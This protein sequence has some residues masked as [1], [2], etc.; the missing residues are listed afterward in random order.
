MEIK[1]AKP[2]VTLLFE[3]GLPEDLFK[4]FSEGLDVEKVTVLVQSRPPSGPQACLE[5]FM[6]PLVATY[7]S[8]SLFD[9]FLGEMGKDLY[10]VLKRK[11]SDTTTKVMTQPRIEPVLVGTKGKLSQD[12]PYSMACSI[13]AEASDGNR[14]KLLLP[15]PGADVDYNEVVGVFL[16]FLSDYHSGVKE[17]DSIG[18]DVNSKPPS[19]YMFVRVNTENKSV[20]WVELVRK[21]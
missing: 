1:L 16:D 6:L 21:F 9:S 3:N 14:F 18:F 17:L 15:K 20:E 13:Y 11:I 4:S 12:N 8:K 7:L 19:G 10:L 5:W 2:D